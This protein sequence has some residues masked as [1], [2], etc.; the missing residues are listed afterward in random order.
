M[1]TYTGTQTRHHPERARRSAAQ[2]GRNSMALAAIRRHADG[3][4]YTVDDLLA[5]ASGLLVGRMSA[6]AFRTALHDDAA[7]AAG[8]IQLLE[9][10]DSR[11]R[12]RAKR[13]RCRRHRVRQP[14]RAYRSHR[15]RPGTRPGC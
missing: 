2:T 4:G 8:R 5:A 9:D 15:C 13:T 14:T 12:P 10:D 3:L 1:T 6:D 7:E 11:R